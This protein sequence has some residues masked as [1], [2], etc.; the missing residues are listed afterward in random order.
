MLQS[1]PSNESGAPEAEKTVFNPVQSLR[2]STPLQ[3]LRRS[4][5]MSPLRSRQFLNES[6]SQSSSP[7]DTAATIALMPSDVQSNT[8]IPIATDHTAY[9]RAFEDQ[10]PTSSGE[11]T[12]WAECIETLLQGD[13]LRQHVHDHN[14]LEE[15]DTDSALL[16]LRHLLDAQLSLS[17]LSRTFKEVDAEEFA[18]LKKHVTELQALQRILKERELS[19]TITEKPTLQLA[20][21]HL[22]LGAVSLNL[23][24]LQQQC[25]TA[26]PNTTSSTNVS[27]PLHQGSVLAKIIQAAWDYLTEQNAIPHWLHQLQSTDWINQALQSLGAPRDHRGTN[28]LEF[29]IHHTKT[30]RKT[31]QAPIKISLIQILAYLVVAAGGAIFMKIQAPNPFTPANIYSVDNTLNVFEPSQ[32]AEL[33]APPSILT[34]VTISVSES[35]SQT[36]T[37]T[38]AQSPS[39]SGSQSQSTSQLQSTSQSKTASQTRTTTQ[40]L[41]ASQTQ[42]GSQSQSQTSSQS[43]SASQTQTASQSLSASQSQS[44]SQTQTASQSLSAS[45]SQ[46]TSQTQ[47]ASQSLSASQ[48]KTPSGTQTAS[49]TMTISQHGSA[50]QS[51]SRSTSQSAT[52]TQTKSSSLSGTS[53]ASPTN[54]MSPSLTP[55]PSQ[56]RTPSASGISQMNLVNCVLALQVA[57]QSITACINGA[58]W[59]GTMGGASSSMNVQITVGSLNGYF[60]SPWGNGVTSVTLPTTTVDATMKGNLASVQICAA[61]I[62]TAITMSGVGPHVSYSGSV[63]FAHRQLAEQLDL[64]TD[65]GAYLD[66]LNSTTTFAEEHGHLRGPNNPG[67]TPEPA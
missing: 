16:Y 44:A 17:R 30:L 14:S 40:T 5:S 4:A 20:L 35:L 46:S 26:F 59:G 1:K 15:T 43:L 13:A 65:T 12:A 10:K 21:T 22:I 52:A 28:A 11:T 18:H 9:E 33:N 24:K 47:T 58:V 64:K 45:Q 23:R 8:E 50:S 31:H 62:V 37:S 6:L 3:R 34:N 51:Q 25:P 67:S 57:C 39:Q 32:P 55:T 60:N 63:P 7:P 38:Q 19:T 41:T 61:N 48:N 66:A 49:Q 42:S 36:L 54:T 29:L 2:H 53:S 27:N 56:T